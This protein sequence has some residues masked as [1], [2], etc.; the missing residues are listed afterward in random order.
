[1]LIAGFPK[2]LADN[3]ITTTSYWLPPPRRYPYT[4]CSKSKQTRRR[5]MMLYFDFFIEFLYLRGTDS[6]IGT[7][8]EL[9]VNK[10]AILFT[11]KC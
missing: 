7:A 10:P 1:V 6:R 8:T 11:R 2:I 4:P 9:P 5:V 3:R